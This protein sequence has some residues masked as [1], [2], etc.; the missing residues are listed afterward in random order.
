[1]KKLTIETLVPT[2]FEYLARDRDGK[3]FVFQNKPEL[4]T[5]VD[6]DTWD[7]V[8]GEVLQITNPISVSLKESNSL[9]G[10]WKE[11]LIDLKDSS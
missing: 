11:S 8:E 10:N 4:T 9:L 6:C 5:D 1:M 7:V 3:I 2:H